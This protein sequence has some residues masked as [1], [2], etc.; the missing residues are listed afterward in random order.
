MP[1]VETIARIR[2]K[3]PGEGKSIR[4]TARE[5]GISRNTV[6]K[7]VRDGKA[8]HRHDRSNRQPRPKPDGFTR[9]LEA[10]PEAGGKRT[11]RDRL[12]LGAIW[13]RP[14]GQGCEAVRRHARRWAAQQG[15][16]IAGAFVPPE[17]DPGEA[18]RFD[19]SHETVLQ[20]HAVHPLPSPGDPGDGGGCP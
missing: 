8:E 13:R 15:G 12:T 1:A 9:A 18:C 14:A 7:V 17:F 19:R 10:K 20:P 6:R 3:H 11:R 2:R 4:G 16:S 5:P